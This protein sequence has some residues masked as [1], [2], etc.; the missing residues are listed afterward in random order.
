MR[1]CPSIRAAPVAGVPAGAT[2]HPVSGFPPAVGRRGSLAQ[3]A[4][5]VKGHPGGKTYDFSN[6]LVRGIILEKLFYVTL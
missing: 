3:K 4:A 5:Q 6:L 1:R 2:C